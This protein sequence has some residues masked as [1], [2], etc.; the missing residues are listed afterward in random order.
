MI[1]LYILIELNINANIRYGSK[2][3]SS[4]NNWLREWILLLSMQ[5]SKQTNLIDSLCENYEVQYGKWF[6]WF[7]WHRLNQ[8]EC[9]N[10][11][12]F[13]IIITYVITQH[14]TLLYFSSLKSKWIR[15]ILILYLSSSVL[16][17]L[18]ITAFHRNRS[19]SK[20]NI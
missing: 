7:H 6:F 16:L 3:F 10:T 9:V 20:S 5:P 2:R 13:V 8:I 15:L 1:S 18:F 17:H 11:I 14:W 4:E 12:I 19:P